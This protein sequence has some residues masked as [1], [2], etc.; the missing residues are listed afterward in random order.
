MIL[1]RIVNGSTGHSLVTEL[2]LNTYLSGYPLAFGT[3]DIKS[4]LT[5]HNSKGGELPKRAA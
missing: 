5:V 4:G 3:I 1:P 2:V